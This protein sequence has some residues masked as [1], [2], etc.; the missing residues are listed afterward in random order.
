MDYDVPLVACD[1]FLGESSG[2]IVGRG[3]FDVETPPVGLAWV[4]ARA[5]SLS[6]LEFAEALGESSVRVAWVRSVNGLLMRALTQRRDPLLLVVTGS[7]EEN[8]EH[9][10]ALS[11]LGKTVQILGPNARIWCGGPGFGVALATSPGQLRDLVDGWS[12]ALAFCPGAPFV[13]PWL[14]DNRWSRQP[15]VG[16]V[17]AAHLRRH[18]LDTLRHPAVV[19]VPLQVPAPSL[20]MSRS[21]D[22]EAVAL[23]HALE[24]QTG[25]VIPSPA[26]M[27]A[28][29]FSLVPGRESQESKSDCDENSLWQQCA[30]ALPQLALEPGMQA[31]R[32][33]VGS[34][35]ALAFLA[36]HALVRAQATRSARKSL[37]L[38]QPL[39]CD[40]ALVER[41]R[42]VLRAAV[43]ELTD[44]ESKVVLR[45]FGF[46]ITRQALA[47]S[48]SG[49][50]TFADRITYPV[51]IKAACTQVQDKAT[52]GAVELNVPHAASV[53][54]AYT[55]VL[56]AIKKHAPHAY[57]EGVLVAEMVNEGFDVH[58]GL[59]RL[60]DE[61]AAWY[62]VSRD[63]NAINEQVLWAP[64]STDL[65]DAIAF[66]HRVVSQ[67][68]RPLESNTA[69]LKALA[70]SFWRLA[71]LF[72]ETQDRILRIALHPLRLGSGDRA[73]VVLD[74]RIV[75]RVHLEG[76]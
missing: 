43:D 9:E 52:I 36:Q 26:V 60:P 32:I 71:F 67:A 41:A 14:S 15:I 73:A 31:P 29:A 16:W 27:R 3:S 47:N 45:G 66:A 57:C 70:E 5:E 61:H 44:Q 22:H 4:H 13:G 7:S 62:A 6:D 50:A 65:N 28:I 10:L 34:E 72:Q 56:D 51:V 38:W 39:D 53:R 69:V 49:A 25:P 20:A 8:A 17:K 19:L 76:L 12:P 24:G 68:I 11:K 48:A 64:A 35:P 33:A 30:R 58:C 42:E 75:Q 18:W 23:A 40:H 37:G 2:V 63:Q 54:R 74:A 21:K 59:L 46:D 55:D 1:D